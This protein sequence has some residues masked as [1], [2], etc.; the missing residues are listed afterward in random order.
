MNAPMNEHYAE[1]ATQTQPLNLD[2]FNF[3]RFRRMFKFKWLRRES[4]PEFDFDFESES[5]SESGFGFAFVV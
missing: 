3:A 1:C 5:E 4:R 2:P